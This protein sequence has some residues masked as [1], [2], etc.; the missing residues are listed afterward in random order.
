[1]NSIFG[2]R[3]FEPGGRSLVLVPESQQ[4]VRADLSGR[5]DLKER[6]REKLME[7]IDPMVA[8][9]GAPHVLQREVRLM[10]SAIATEEKIQFNE[11]EE[12]ALADE[13]T[14]DMVGLGPLEPLLQDD[15]ITDILANGPF[16][17]YVEKRGKLE[18]TNT[19]FR[20]AQHV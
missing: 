12:A 20:N 5:D 17:I 14:D 19:R 6:V 4:G 15:D 8:A 9:R 3:I 1:M 18:K 16:D 7:Q 13:L 10:V 11:I 2:R